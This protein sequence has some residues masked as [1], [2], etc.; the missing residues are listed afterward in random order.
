MSRYV[1]A[2]PLEASPWG[3]RSVTETLDR[4]QAVNAQAKARTW[5]HFYARRL[6]ITD[7]AVI[8]TAFFISQ[9][10]WL[11][12]GVVEL[13]SSNSDPRWFRITYTTVSVVLVVLWMLFLDL[14][15]ARDHKNIG[16]GTTEYKRI[17]DATIRLFGVLAIVAFITKADL[18]R[19]YFLTA[20]PL[21]VFFLL[22]GRWMWRQWL[23]RKQADGLY[24]S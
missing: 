11:D 6:F 13:A 16:A 17:A 21:G 15:A 19:G 18:G 2:L 7:L 10:L 5:K 9:L 23:R 22:L 14:F 12:S 8:A 4:A 3:R 24:T 20:L 1:E